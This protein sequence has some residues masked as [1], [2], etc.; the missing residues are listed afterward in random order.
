MKDSGH[1]SIS[2]YKYSRAGFIRYLGRT[3]LESSE[4]WWEFR[5]NHDQD[6][7]PE[8]NS[9]WIKRFKYIVEFRQ[10][11]KKNF[12]SIFRKISPESLVDCCQNLWLVLSESFL[13]ISSEYWTPFHQILEQHSVRIPSWIPSN[14]FLFAEFF[15][16]FYYFFHYFL[17]GIQRSIFLTSNFLN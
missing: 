9:I 6:V 13:I 2:F 3:P 12:I 10:N 16:I 5:E 8:Q 4:Y 7:S 17:R 1:N 15:E 11:L 14:S